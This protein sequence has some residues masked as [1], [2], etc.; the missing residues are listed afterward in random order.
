MLTRATR[1]FVIAAP[2]VAGVLLLIFGTQGVTSEFFGW[3]LIAIAAMV[4]M[5]NWFIRMTFDEDKFDRESSEREA[6]AAHQRVLLE[7][8]KRAVVEPHP[9]H[10]PHPLRSARRLAR[11]PRRPS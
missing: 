1:W 7:P 11:R 6:R 5:S 2:A 4:W 3:T 10:P 8:P 9:P